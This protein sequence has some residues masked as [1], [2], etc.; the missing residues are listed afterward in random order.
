MSRPVQKVDKPPACLYARHFL[1]M[2]MLAA[3]MPRHGRAL[4][5]LV[6]AE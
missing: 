1:L 5:H 6:R 3:A 2:A 4:E